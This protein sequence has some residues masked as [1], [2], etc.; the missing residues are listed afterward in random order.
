[1]IPV[2]RRKDEALGTSVSGRLLIGPYADEHADEH[3]YDAFAPYTDIINVRPGER[4]LF[5]SSVFV[6]LESRG[7]RHGLKL[8]DELS[9]EVLSERDILVA[10]EYGQMQE[11]LR[12]GGLELYYFRAGFRRIGMTL[13]H[14]PIMHRY[15]ERA[16][17]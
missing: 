2:S 10:Q 15:H 4:V 5:I 17:R 16:T 13:E 14:N 8:V 12:P 11:N 6:S 1:M 3:H 9:D 7:Q